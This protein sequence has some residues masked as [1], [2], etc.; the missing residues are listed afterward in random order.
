MLC[1]VVGFYF[2]PD[3]LDCLIGMFNIFTLKIVLVRQNS[4][5]TGFIGSVQF[6][7]FPRTMRA[8][9]ASAG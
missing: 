3:N 1:G 9:S 5:I 2:Y 4:V 8:S 6:N 7:I